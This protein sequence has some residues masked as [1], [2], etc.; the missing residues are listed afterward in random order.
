V[1]RAHS[2]PQ[3]SYNDK[4]ASGQECSEAISPAPTSTASSSSCP[5]RSIVV[6]SR[7]SESGLSSTIHS[8]GTYQIQCLSNWIVDVS[9]SPSSF[10]DEITIAR[11]F[12]FIPMRLGTSSALDMAVRCLTVH[13]LGIT[14]EN[15]QVVL[16][17]RLMYGKALSCLQKAIYD[18]VQAT[19]SATLCATITLCLYE[20]NCHS[21]ILIPVLKLSFSCSRA[22][23]LTLG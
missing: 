8:P 4:G 16:Q 2:R 13:H 21:L 9:R 1:D 3:S 14:Q 15:Q 10:P 11:L 23:K 5:K 18:P 7:S 17:S 6:S 20:V 12:C 19:T 22:R